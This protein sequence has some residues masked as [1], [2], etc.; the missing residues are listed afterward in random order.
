MD[1]IIYG[2]NI[3]V[4]GLGRVGM[5]VV[6]FFVVFGVNVKVGVRKFEYLVCI[7]EMGL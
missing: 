7:V 2:L 1:F 3:F 4:L 5:S 6:R